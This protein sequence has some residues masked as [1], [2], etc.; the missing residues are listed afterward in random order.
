MDKKDAS[1]HRA[2][3]SAIKY[4]LHRARESIIILEKIVLMNAYGKTPKTNMNKQKTGLKAALK[5]AQ[6]IVILLI[7]MFALINVYR[8]VHSDVRVLKIDIQIVKLNVWRSVK[9]LIVNVMIFNAIFVLHNVKRRI[10]M[11]QFLIFV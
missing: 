7:L 10:K 8:I 4:P 6:E 2:I 5:I 3:K 1:Q 11:L 9:I